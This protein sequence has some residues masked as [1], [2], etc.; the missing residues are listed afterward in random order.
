MP[1][2]N[3]AYMSAQQPRFPIEGVSF[4][5]FNPDTNQPIERVFPAGA[6]APAQYGL[7]GVARRDGEKSCR[8]GHAVLAFPGPHA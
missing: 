1:I 7:V 4:E 8:G 3:D 5:A 6:G 2:F